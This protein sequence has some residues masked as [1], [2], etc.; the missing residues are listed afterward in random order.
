MC[1]MKR[2]KAAKFLASK[3]RDGATALNNFAAIRKT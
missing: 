3:E 1:Q 2:A